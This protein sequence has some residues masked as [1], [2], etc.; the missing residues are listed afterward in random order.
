MMKTKLQV[1]IKK[2]FRLLDDIWCVVNKHNENLN[3]KY[4]DDNYVEV[5]LDDILGFVNCQKILFPHSLQNIE[6]VI[7]NKELIVNEINTLEG[8]RHNILTI[9]SI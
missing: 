7:N 9:T 5:T 2:P 4:E 6:C 1:E 3:Q 8:C